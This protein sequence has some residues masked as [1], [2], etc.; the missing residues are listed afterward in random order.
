[1]KNVMILF[2]GRSVEGIL[3]DAKK[4]FPDVEVLVITRHND[5]LQ[6]P[7]GVQVATVGGF[8]PNSE[9][10]YTVIANGGTSAQLIPVLKSLIE[11][12]SLFEV[13]DLQRDGMSKLW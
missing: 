1:M 13:F 4:E 8:V 11:T 12:K 10:S 7:A 5:Q 9:T 6:P 2:L 3:A